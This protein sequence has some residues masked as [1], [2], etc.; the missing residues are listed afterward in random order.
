MNQNSNDRIVTLR[1]L[2][3]VFRQRFVILVAVAVLVSSCGYLL[4]WLTYDPMYSSTATMYILRG[5]ESGDYSVGEANTEYALALKVV[6]D[7]TY[8]LK[9]R[10]VVN[11]VI[12][13]LNLSTSYEVLSANISTNNPTSTRVLEVTARAATPE[14]AK[15]VVDSLCDIGEDKIAE[16]MGYDQVNLYEH[17][18]LAKRPCNSISILLYAIIGAAAAAVVY[19]CFVVALLL[20]DR[21]R[22]EEDIQR[23]LGLSI[24]GDIVNVYDDRRSRPGNRYGSK[25]VANTKKRGS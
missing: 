14:L 10:S 8:L 4:A 3:N 12:T 18:T 24:L 6:N 21:I 5:N 17:G 1:D 9:S 20:D 25:P 7:C 11:Q 23:Y 15:S 13:D 16:A 2:W 19:V 22:S